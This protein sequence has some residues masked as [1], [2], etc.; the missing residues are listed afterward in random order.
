MAHCCFVTGHG[1]TFTKSYTVLAW[2]LTT[3]NIKHVLSLGWE[4]ESA[5]DSLDR[6]NRWRGGFPPCL[7]LSNISSPH[8]FL[9]D[10]PCLQSV[11]CLCNVPLCCLSAFGGLCF[12]CNVYLMVFRSTS[13]STS[14]LAEK[15]GQ[16]TQLITVDEK[17]V[18][19][20]PWSTWHTDW[21]LSGLLSSN[22]PPG[23]TVKKL[24]NPN[25]LPKWACIGQ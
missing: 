10:S 9:Q 13:T 11:T 20:P 4:R 22:Y 16:D 23:K 2:Q 12:A 17:L 25:L 7:F 19:I 3:A 1:C 21:C 18:R 14:R 6:T 8:R 5:R 15:P 24:P